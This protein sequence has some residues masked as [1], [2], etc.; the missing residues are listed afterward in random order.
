M[1]EFIDRMGEAKMKELAVSAPFHCQLMKPAQERLSQ[2][3]AKVAIQPCSF[4]VYANYSAAPVLEPEEIRLSLA[5]QVCGRV[6]WVESM[7]NAIKDISPEQAIEF[8]A[9]AVLSGLLKRIEASI[10]R[11]GIATAGD[12][13]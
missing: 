8:G 12:L 3:L 9:G 4:P 13:D 7:E 5:N 6:R 2:E 11:R 10:P 1:E